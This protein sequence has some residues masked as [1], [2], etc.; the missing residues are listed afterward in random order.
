MLAMAAVGVGTILMA[1]TA[2]T[3]IQLA[4]PDELRGRVMGLIMTSFGAAQVLGLPIGLGLAHQAGAI[5]LFAAALYHLWLTVGATAPA[6][7]AQA[8]PSA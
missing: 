7:E 3:V 2:N 4:V 6:T 1:A 8:A 5:L